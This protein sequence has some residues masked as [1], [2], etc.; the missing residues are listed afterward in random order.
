MLLMWGIYFVNVVLVRLGVNVVL[1]WL[2]KLGCWN[3]LYLLNIFI[4]VVGSVIFVYLLF[5]LNVILFV[6]VFFIN[7]VVLLKILVLNIGLYFFKFLL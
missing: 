5:L 4:V 1:C 2:C 7:I 6:L 3:R